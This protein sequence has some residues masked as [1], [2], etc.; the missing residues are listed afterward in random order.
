MTDP[1]SVRGT[2]VVSGTGRVA[3]EPDM[4]ELRLGV[5]VSRA[6]VAAARAAAAETMTAIL[7]AVVAAGV[8]TRDVPR[9]SSRSSHA[10][11]TAMAPRR[12]S[13]ATTS[14]TSSR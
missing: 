14:P 10:T 9:P 13:S 6:S 3:V 1:T 8:A 5:A 11:T 12:P 7:G 4:A 2:I